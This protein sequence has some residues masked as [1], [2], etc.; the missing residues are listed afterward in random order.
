MTAIGLT[1]ATILLSPRF[2]GPDWRLFRLGS[3]VATGLS[4]FAPIGHAWVLCGP[5]YV[6]GIGV[7]YYLLEGVLLVIGCCFW[8][9]DTLSTISLHLGKG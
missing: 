9:V 6:W 8:E 7:P 1:T 3:F 5:L 4:A 2:R